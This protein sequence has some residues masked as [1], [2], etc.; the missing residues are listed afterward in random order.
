MP[1]KRT[2][3]ELLGEIDRRTEANIKL[4]KDMEDARI[5]AHRHKQ[6]YESAVKYRAQAEQKLRDAKNLVQMYAQ[7]K[8]GHDAYE[9]DSY[10]MPSPDPV[11]EVPEELRFLR[12]LYLTLCLTDNP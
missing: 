6:D 1:D 7:V 11:P 12:Q 4:A 8:H 10:M 2:K 5:M 9:A 3:T